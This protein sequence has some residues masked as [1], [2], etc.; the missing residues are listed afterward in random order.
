[1]TCVNKVENP[2]GDLLLYQLHYCTFHKVS[3]LCLQLSKGLKI[4]ETTYKRL[5]YLST[6]NC[7]VLRNKK[8]NTMSFHSTMTI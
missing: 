1:M 5:D 2:Q 4:E 3:V 7:W 6:E 8:Y